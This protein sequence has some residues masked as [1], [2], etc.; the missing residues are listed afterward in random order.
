MPAGPS[1]T[2]RLVCRVIAELKGRLNYFMKTGDDSKMP[3]DIIGAIFITV[4][5]HHPFSG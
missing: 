5:A 4:R 3:S 1:F 2:Y